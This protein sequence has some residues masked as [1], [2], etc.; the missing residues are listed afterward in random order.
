VTCQD[1]AEFLMDYLEGNLPDDQRR[2]FDNHLSICSDCRNY[3]SS[4]K[5]AVLLGK[6]AFG[7][8]DLNTPVPEQ[9]VHSI[10]KA[11]AAGSSPSL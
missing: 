3:L 8:D 2:V 10:L 5:T 6:A 9:L 11:R 7:Q 1:V 4:Y